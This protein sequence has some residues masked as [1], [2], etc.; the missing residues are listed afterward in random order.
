ME[1]TIRRG[2]TALGILAAAVMFWFALANRT[3]SLAVF[4]ERLD[5]RAGELAQ[6]L[7]GLPS[8][9]TSGGRGADPAAKKRVAVA[10]ALGS[11]IRALL[12]AEEE[13]GSALDLALNRRVGLAPGEEAAKFT[14]EDRD[15]L[16]GR[17]GPILDVG[18]GIERFELLEP[19]QR[20]VS[21]GGGG[22]GF[23]DLLELFDWLALSV[24]QAANRGDEEGVVA[25]IEVIAGLSGDLLASRDQ[26]RWL[27]GCFGLSKALAS[28]LEVERTGG[29]EPHE[30]EV[31][32]RRALEQLL[33]VVESSEGRNR[34]ISAIELAESQL[35]SVREALLERFIAALDALGEIYDVGPGAESGAESSAGG[36]V[37]REWMDGLEALIARQDRVFALLDGPGFQPSKAAFAPLEDR[38][39]PVPAAMVAT[40]L[41]GSVDPF[42]RAKAE[43]ARARRWI[44]AGKVD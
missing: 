15:L 31:S 8:R 13:T 35:P 16:L 7:A 20:E 12:E 38:D 24:S 30:E 23:S 41:W 2:L 42:L 32:D 34:L 6:Q 22:S 37:P 39:L 5:G 25:G 19:A 1:K 9:H 27:L 18:L 28:V 43:S 36:S 10:I 3:V 21:L 40:P 11:R 17:V 4:R 44:A 14:G 26:L 29:V 33:A